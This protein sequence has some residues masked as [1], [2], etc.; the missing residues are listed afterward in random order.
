MFSSQSTEQKAMS[1]YSEMNK[2][3][4]MMEYVMKVRKQFRCY[5]D[6]HYLRVFH[7]NWEFI[8][9]YKGFEFCFV[10]YEKASKS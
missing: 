9:G 2:C 10:D 3:T 4:I 1:L 5:S 8:S 7:H 6:F